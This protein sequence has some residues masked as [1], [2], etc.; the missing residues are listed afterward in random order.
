MRSGYKA[1]LIICCEGCNFQP[2]ERCEVKKNKL[3]MLLKTY[4]NGS[5]KCAVPSSQGSAEAPLHL[6]ADG[7]WG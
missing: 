3:P 7:G 5:L 1:A 4:D 2:F 6:P